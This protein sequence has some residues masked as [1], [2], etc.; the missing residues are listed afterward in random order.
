MQYIPCCAAQS[1]AAC[2]VAITVLSQ[3][4]V[5]AIRTI[6]APA[7]LNSSSA[8][9]PDAVRAPLGGPGESAIGKTFRPLSTITRSAL[10][11][12]T[13]GVC[14]MIDGTVATART[15]PS[16]RLESADAVIVIP[17]VWSSV[18]PA[19]PRKKSTAGKQC[20]G[21]SGWFR[22][23]RDPG[24]CRIHTKFICDDD[25]RH[26]GGVSLAEEETRNGTKVRVTR[27]GP[28]GGEQVCRRC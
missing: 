16:I 5:C 26:R 24:P 11:V 4:V 15:N 12:T 20:S 2:W 21:R 1:S 27:R 10:M 28:S 3:L 7:S 23:G 19:P 9:S 13:E 8:S 14:A 22:H 6:S 18:P 17:F 25:G